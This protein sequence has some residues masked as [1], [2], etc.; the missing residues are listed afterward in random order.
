MP[1]AV[2][3]GTVIACRYRLLSRLNSGGMGVIWR[4]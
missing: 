1:V 3:G 2:A 4:A